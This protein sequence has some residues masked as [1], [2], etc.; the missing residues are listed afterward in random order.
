MSEKDN[1]TPPDKT[2]PTEENLPIVWRPTPAY[3]TNAR[4]THFMTTNKLSDY[5][6]LLTW[7][8]ADVGRFW[9]AV[10]HDLD[11]EFYTPYT[12]PVDLSQGIAWATW[13]KDGR[14]NYVHN[15]LDKHAKGARA[16]AM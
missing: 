4:L 9:D 1:Q 14:L 5:A 3:T 7:A 15:A 12:T 16:Q 11:I 6:E 8:A 10:V 2:D 13:F